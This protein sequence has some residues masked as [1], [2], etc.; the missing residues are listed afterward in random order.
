MIPLEIEVKFYLQDRHAVRQRIL[1]A[2]AT[3]A[4]A[5]CFER[6]LRF[7]DAQHSLSYRNSVLRLRQDETAKLTF[8]SKPPVRD[9]EFKIFQE[10]EV[11]VSNFDTMKQIL[12]SLGFTAYQT[13]EKYRETFALNECELCLD[14]MPYGSFLEIEG[15]KEQIRQIADILGLQWEKRILRSYLSMFAD[16]KD[17]L[18]LPFSDVTFDNFKTIDLDFSKYCSVFEA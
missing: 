16:L 7:D 3:L 14:V 5:N 17:M 8:K 13:Y 2:G 12:E 18:N 4:H 11:V 10:L 6:N 9:K 15:G 1:D